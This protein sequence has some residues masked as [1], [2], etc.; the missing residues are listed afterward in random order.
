MSPPRAAMPGPAARLA[1]S[2][3]ARRACAATLAAASACIIPDAGIVVQDEFLNM[4]AV[5]IV[6][7]TPVTARAD[8]DCA[9]RTPL[10]GCPQIP[11][12]LPSGLIR[13]PLCVC[14]GSDGE[15][16][17]GGGFDIFVEDPDVDAAGDPKDE[18]LGA[19]FLDMPPDAEDPGDYRAYTKRLPPEQPARLYR[20]DQVQT[21]E[22][23]DPHL[24][25]WTLGDGRPVD[26]CNDDDGSKIEPGLH[27]LRLLVT[28]RPWYRPVMLD[29]KGEP[30][31]DEDGELLFYDPVIGMPDLP[32]GATYDTTTYVFRCYDASSL[33][34]GIECNCNEPEE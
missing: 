9:E 32:G 24:K 6:E 10:S 4:G 20:A 1:T 26:L 17:L 19:L 18:I 27:E 5:R 15:F 11:V 3:A 16:G 25:S 22:R 8:E 28:D 34:A 31:K 14:P 29:E 2:A 13:A 7:P 33:P 30:L 12:S 23:P 21:I